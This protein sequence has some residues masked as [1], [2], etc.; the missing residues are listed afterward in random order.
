M[1]ADCRGNPQSRVPVAVCGTRGN[2]RFRT[3]SASVPA[4]GHA[5][6]MRTHIP[7]R[8]F[9]LQ[10]R[11]RWALARRRFFRRRGPWKKEGWPRI[12]RMCARAS[13]RKVRGDDTRITKEQRV[14]GIP[15]HGRTSLRITKRPSLCLMHE[16]SA[17]NC[18]HENCARLFPR[19]TASNVGP[20]VPRLCGSHGRG[21]SGSGKS[22]ASGGWSRFAGTK[23][24]DRF[25]H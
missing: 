2:F 16:N 21:S 22:A 1:R 5:L 15:R 19:R 10:P 11:A 6:F 23:G 13:P 3:R 17:A 24:K 9:Y 4:P 20:S 25:E 8:H 7:D 12:S 14:G 18:F